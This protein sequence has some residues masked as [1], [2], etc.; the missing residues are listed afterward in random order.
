[1]I[2]GVT[3]PKS[4]L[5]C[6]EMIQNYRKTAKVVTPNFCHQ[7]LSSTANSSVAA[8][9][10]NMISSALSIER[11]K[12]DEFLPYL[13]TMLG[14]RE[15]SRQ[16]IEKICQ[17]IEKHFPQDMYTEEEYA[18]AEKLKSY[19]YHTEKS[20]LIAQQ[21]WEAVQKKYADVSAESYSVSNPRLNIDRGLYEAYP[22]RLAPDIIKLLKNC[23]KITKEDIG[24]V[25]KAD[26]SLIIEMLDLYEP[27]VQTNFKQNPQEVLAIIEGLSQASAKLSIPM[28]KDMCAGSLKRILRALGNNLQISE[29]Q[30]GT[31]QEDIILLLLDAQG[32]R[33][34]DKEFPSLKQQSADIYEK[35]W[36]DICKG[37]L[38]EMFLIKFLAEK[39]DIKERLSAITYQGTAEL[40]NISLYELILRC[41]S[42]SEADW[43]LHSFFAFPLTRENIAHWS[44][45]PEI[46]GSR[47]LEDY[48]LALREGNVTIAELAQAVN[49]GAQ[50]NFRLI[51]LA[52][53][54]P[55]VQKPRTDLR[56]KSIEALLNVYCEAYAQKAEPPEEV[57]K[58]IYDVRF[59][60][61]GH[62]IQDPRKPVDLFRQAVSELA[63]KKLPPELI[64][65]TKTNY[66]YNR[67]LLKKPFTK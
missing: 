63:Y 17:V 16:V 31:E 52:N 20:A 30:T 14:R 38:I 9:F 67:L 48:E 12:L 43:L 49:R 2:L 1:M 45:Y 64:K 15:T 62:L 47:L 40:L 44:R 53:G 58:T 18:F 39:I 13:G 19:E 57:Y 10:V 36:Q 50:A 35:Y 7:I 56:D 42:M 28:Q 34:A 59:G 21:L 61:V 25:T 60:K 66:G 29:H 54:E 46:S 37:H 4:V 32:I 5:Q 27:Y 11:A 26:I 33:P 24:T 8:K 23:E 22:Q 41:N 3:H 65:L 55:F 6:N 51:K